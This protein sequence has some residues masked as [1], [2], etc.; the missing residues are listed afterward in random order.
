MSLMHED[1][2]RAH[3]SARLQEARAE[4]RATLVAR[5]QQAAKRAER[6]ALKARLLLARAQ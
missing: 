1:L 3:I 2:A 5:A 6:K 4:R